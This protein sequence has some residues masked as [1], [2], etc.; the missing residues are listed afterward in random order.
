MNKLCSAV[1]STPVRL[2]VTGMSL[3]A[4]GSYGAGATR[5]RGGIVDALGLDWM[6]YGHGFA[7]FELVIWVGAA[8]VLAA[9]LRLGR[10]MI[11]RG[12]TVDTAESSDLGWKTKL[13]EVNRTFMWWLIPLSLSGPLF[14]RDVYSYIIQGAMLR[15]GFDPYT[16]G[17]AVNPGP[18]LYEV[19]ADW[20]NT[21]TPYGPLHLGLGKLI[22]SITGDSVTGGII[23]FRL[24]CLLSVLAIAWTV[25][26]I[27]LRL[28]GDPVLAQWIGVLNP[29]VLF[30]LVGG[31][32]NEALMLALVGAGITAALALKP[33]PG[34]AAGAALVGVAVALKATAIIAMPFM[35]W[36]ALTRKSPIRNWRTTFGRLGEI[37]GVGVMLSAITLGVLAVCTWIT[38]AGWGWISELSGNVKVINPLAAPSAVAG[39]ISSVAVYFTDTITFN[40]V[41]DIARPISALCLVAGLIGSWLVFRNTPRRAVAGMAAAHGAI[42]VFNSVVLPWYHSSLLVLVGSIRPRRWVVNITVLGTIILCMSFA[43]GGNNR[44]YEPGW[45][46]AITLSAIAATR[47]L[48]HGVWSTRLVWRGV[49]G[50]GADKAVDYS[51]A[52]IDNRD[53][54]ALPDAAPISAGR[55]ETTHAPQ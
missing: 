18:L 17:P 2:G 31:M 10:E 21:T 28:G 50:D 43:G 42:V 47:W 4:V 33:L 9:W 51:V 32:H 39:I 12:G 16:Q 49:H 7:V 52:G 14:S 44:F 40:T 13:S 8:V 34:A 41:V 37:I 3:M 53:D 48:T 46:I 5:Y 25:P 27:T 38:G 19:S 20:R 54:P 24:L 45:M 29:L 11:W 30:H 1:A 36:I 15:D 6:T 35:V 26:R 23:V 22:T 55:W